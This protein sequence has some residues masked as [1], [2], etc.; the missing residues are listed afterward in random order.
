MTFIIFQ[1]PIFVKNGTLG[2]SPAGALRQIGSVR[3]V[4][5]SATKAQFL[6]F[7]DFDW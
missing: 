7:N 6:S 5:E 3:L 2:N 1:K 4:I